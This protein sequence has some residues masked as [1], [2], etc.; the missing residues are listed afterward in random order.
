MNFRLL[1]KISP[2]FVGVFFW[3]FAGSVMAEIDSGACSVLYNDTNVTCSLKLSLPV[4]VVDGSEFIGKCGQATG[5]FETNLKK[6]IGYGSDPTNTQCKEIYSLFKDFEL[7][8]LTPASDVES[9][10]KE[11][12][13]CVQ[14]FLSCQGNIGSVDVTNP[15]GQCTYDILQD[16]KKKWADV[17]GADFCQ[18]ALKL[19]GSIQDKCDSYKKAIDTEKKKPVSP[20]PKFEPDAELPAITAAKA[21]IEADT[22]TVF[23]QLNTTSV[24]ALFG[25]LVN[26]ALGI[27]GSIALVMFV[28]GG[29]LWMTAAG[30]SA[31]S[32]KARDVV[33]WATLG[34]TV[35]FASYAILK[36]VFEIFN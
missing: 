21:K 8:K 17:K 28:Y 7:Q 22:K 6:N 36:F 5:V 2:V 35:I 14:L 27:L 15:E 1:K 18:Q 33:L 23:D 3:G 34:A 12:Y 32:E 4:P 10:V 19:D 20:Y 13:G 30:D 11:L 16:G 26:G 29:I 31:K 9:C 25:R 24:S